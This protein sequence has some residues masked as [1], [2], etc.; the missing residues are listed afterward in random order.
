MRD[1]LLAR[2]SE[3]RMAHTL[4]VSKLP[5]IFE[6]LRE[7][8]HKLTTWECDRLEEWEIIY[9]RKGVDGLSEKQL[10]CIEKM[11]MKT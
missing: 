9:E 10:E 5:Q 7:N 6:A 1:L 11:H 4:D 2:Q 8:T 3:N